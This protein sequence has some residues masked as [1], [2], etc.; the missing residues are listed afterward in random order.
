MRFAGTLLIVAFLLVGCGPTPIRQI[1]KVDGITI[2]L[3]HPEQARL[4]QEI[5]MVVIVTDETNRTVNN[6]IVTLDLTMLEMP[7]GQN[8]PIAD[9]LGGGRYRIRTALTMVGKW[10]TTVIVMLNG[11]E[12]RAVFAQAVT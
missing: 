11:R 9:A 6:A 8:R 1:Q 3:E 7:M 4:N 2:G 5:E 10:Q 12:Y